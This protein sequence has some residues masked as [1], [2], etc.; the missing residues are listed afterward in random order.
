MTPCP[1]YKY[2]SLLFEC[3]AVFVA[4]YVVGFKRR[5]IGQRCDG[6]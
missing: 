5:G 6:E 2:L 3:L 4:S 1:G